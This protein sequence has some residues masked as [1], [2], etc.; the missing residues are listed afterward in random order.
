MIVPSLDVCSGCFLRNLY[1]YVDLDETYSYF[2][3]YIN[4]SQVEPLLSKHAGS[5]VHLSMS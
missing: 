2:H 1:V 5:E 3:E 4:V